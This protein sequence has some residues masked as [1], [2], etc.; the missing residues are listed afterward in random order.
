MFTATRRRK[1]S[2]ED[3]AIEQRLEKKAAAGDVY[4]K[5]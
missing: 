5:V 4:Q 2:S 1:A 3:S